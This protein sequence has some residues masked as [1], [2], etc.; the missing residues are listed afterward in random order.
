LYKIFG[1]F[2]SLA[3]MVKIFDCLF[4]PDGDEKA[5]RNDRN[6]DEEVVPCTRG[7]VG[8]VYI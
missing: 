2:G 8:C 5:N 3:P 1:H 7:L 4:E 6:M